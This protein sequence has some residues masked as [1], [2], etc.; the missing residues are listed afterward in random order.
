MKKLLL[1]FLLLCPLR[2]LAQTD[3]IT[4]QVTDVATQTWNDGTWAVKLRLP[5]NPGQTTFYILGTTTPVPNQ[6]QDGDLDGTGGASVIVTPNASIAPS[7]TVWDF[8][9][10]PKASSQC[11]DETITAVGSSQNV[12]L[13]P[14]EPVVT[15]QG[16]PSA[17]RDSEI[18]GAIQG[19]MY[20][21]LVS[22]IFRYCS[23]TPCSSN[24]TTFSGST[25]N[26]SNE[27]GP[28]GAINSVNVTY[29]LS[30][31][32]IAGTLK[33]V[34]NGLTLHSGAGNDFTLSGNTITM[35]YAPTSGSNFICWY[36]Y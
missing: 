30:H 35:A 26:E 11:Y 7:G 21:N 19:S 5:L 28:S 15:A 33:L 32:P 9:V 25:V 22:S 20:W 2:L 12:T 23:A 13:N 31:A 29:T 27:E 4:L 16:I 14:S 10:C 3:T 1:L 36:E 17:Y 24:W 18:T 34:L 6:T 8:T